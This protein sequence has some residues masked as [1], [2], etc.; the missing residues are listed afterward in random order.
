MSSSDAISRFA[1][2]EALSGAL[3]THIT[4]GAAMRNR[5]TMLTASLLALLSACSD[6]PTA[7]SSTATTVQARLINPERISQVPS[8]V[9][10]TR[11]AVA[12][13]RVRGGV[14][15]R[16][17][18][19]LALAQ[20]RGVL[21]TLKLQNRRAHASQAGAASGASAVVLKF[22]YPLDAAAID[23]LLASQ[24]AELA[25]GAATTAFDAGVA[26]GKTTGEAVLAQAA[27]DNFG[28]TAPGQPPVGPAYWVT[29][30]LP[31]NRGFLGARPFFLHST[32][33]LRLGPPPAFGSAE[34][35]TQLAEVRGFS[36]TRTVEQTAIAKKWA[37]FGDV[38]FDSV[39]TVLIEKHHRSELVSVAILAY[40]NAAV[41]DAFVACFDTKYTYWHVRPTQADPGITLAVPLPNHPSWPSAHSCQSGAWATILDIAFPSE[42]SYID[43]LQQ[44]AS[45][46][47]IYAGIHYR[48]D[49][50][51]GTLLGQRAAWFAIT[52]GGLE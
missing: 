14:P 40:G 33:E 6:A 16:R 41:F 20:Y 28:L 7:T 39:A 22:F 13:Y 26:L 18:V 11:K 1:R 37:P 45:L 21:E 29:G 46:S 3:R 44:E 43:A 32:S 34:F 49:T 8:S 15:S 24:R 23:A 35:L 10:W 9:T 47:R 2:V 17:S 27:T 5:L 48:S 50:D 42:R 30:G 52:R 31:I 4:R 38:I 36:D 12:L 19:Y 51:A 25:P